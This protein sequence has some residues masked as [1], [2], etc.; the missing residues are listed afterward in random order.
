MTSIAAGLHA[1]SW[2]RDIHGVLGIREVG[3]YLLLWRQ[4]ESISLT[5]QPGQLLWCW[6]ASGTYS[7]KSCY[8]AMFHG[9]RACA[10]WKLLWKTW[11]PPRVKFFH[12]LVVKDCCWTAECLRRRGLQHHPLCLLCDQEPESMQHLLL[13]CP[14]SRQVWYDILSWLRLACRPPVNEASLNDWWIIAR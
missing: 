9:S 3:Q 8:L 14:F 5:N 4:V 6:T 11:A 10:S 12:W 1:H 2:A 7:A 13:V